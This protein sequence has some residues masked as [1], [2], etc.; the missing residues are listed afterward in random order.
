MEKYRILSDRAFYA[1]SAF[2][3]KGLVVTGAI[4]GVLFRFFKDG[5]E[6]FLPEGAKVDVCDNVICVFDKDVEGCCRLQLK[7]YLVEE[8]FDYMTYEVVDWELLVH[9]GTTRDLFLDFPDKLVDFNVSEGVPVRRSE[10]E[11][12]LRQNVE[13][14]CDCSAEYVGLAYVKE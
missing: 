13:K 3:Y 7:P 8:W 5:K 10:F 12:V 9:A 1:E 11:R 4:V 2:E 6:V 14:F